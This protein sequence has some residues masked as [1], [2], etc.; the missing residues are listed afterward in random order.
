MSCRLALLRRCL[1]IRLCCAAVAMCV[2]TSRAADRPNILLLLADNWRWPTAGALGDPMARTPA[3]D[4]IAREGVLF[5]HTFNPVPSCSPTRASLWSALRNDPHQLTNVAGQ[6]EYADALKQHRAG[7][8]EWMKQTHDP[9][10]DPTYN[11]WDTFP[12][13]G[14]PYKAREYASG[15]ETTS[16]L[17]NEM[18]HPAF[19]SPIFFAAF[20]AAGILY[21]ATL[22]AAPGKRPNII[23]IFIGYAL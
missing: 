2:A 7:V 16:S 14:K 23:L 6:P 11:G 4:R 18:K 20:L 22:H 10:V 3:F 21:P 17:G 9:R 13:Y 5:T 1:I 12:Y 15:H 8:D 19:L